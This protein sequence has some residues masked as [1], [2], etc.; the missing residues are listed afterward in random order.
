MCD[1]TWRCCSST[2]DGGCASTGNYRCQLTCDGNGN[3]DYAT[4]CVLCNAGCVNECVDAQG[5][6]GGS[7]VT[8]NCAAGDYCDPS[9]AKCIS[10]LCD[11]GWFCCSSTG[12]NGCATA[13]DY[14]CQLTCDGN[15]NCDYATNCENCA[16]KTSTDSDGGDVPET[17]GSVTDYTGCS[18][19]VCTG[20][21]YTD[22]CVDPT[23][24]VEYYPDGTG[25][26]YNHYYC[27][28]FEVAATGDTA[29]DPTTTGSCTGGTR[30]GCS[31]GA[32]TTGSGSS[33]TEGCVDPSACPGG[34]NCVFKE[35]YAVD[36]ND[37][38]PGKDTCTSKTYDPD[39]NSNTCSACLG[40]GH[41]NLGGD[42]TTCCGDDNSEYIKTRTCASS[43][44][45][46]SSSDDACCDASSDCVYSSTC[47]ENGHVEDVDGDGYKERCSS[48][49]WQDGEP[50]TSSI[51]SPA[52]N[53]WHRTDFDVSVSDSDNGG[54][55][56]GTCYY[57]VWSN[58]VLT[59]DTTTRACSSSVTLTVG[60]T[61]DCRDQGSGMCKIEVWAVDGAGNEGIHINRSFSIDWTA[62]TFDSYS[63]QG[64]DYD[65]G[66]D[67]WVKGGK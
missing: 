28:D 25:Y 18:N 48:G 11:S 30:A 65:T 55:G 9:Q 24:L 13:G 6:S 19:S 22:F 20:N 16:T 39:T 29:D 10:G 46:N 67:C 2:G 1:S 64:C 15:G 21:A 40:S 26:E 14:R 42:I 52:E 63:V 58:E 62:P 23:H 41:W 34:A 33:C 45:T 57:R 44:C 8:A 3:C 7:C 47:Y 4:N 17:Q 61:A 38:C 35:C 50:P 53:S 31:G 43:V 32:F 12:D 66:T 27:S 56:L 54:S 36:S 49:T 59:K 5:C 60:S 51:T 37:G